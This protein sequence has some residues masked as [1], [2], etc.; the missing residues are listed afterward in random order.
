MP[1]VTIVDE[2]VTNEEE[3]VNDYEGEC[4]VPVI[5]YLQNL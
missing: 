3:D 1:T 2:N 4:N 5:H